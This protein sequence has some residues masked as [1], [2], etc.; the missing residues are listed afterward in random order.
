LLKSLDTYK[1]IVNTKTARSRK[2]KEWNWKY[3]RSIRSKIWSNGSF[4]SR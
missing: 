4:N 1:L 2:A 3:K